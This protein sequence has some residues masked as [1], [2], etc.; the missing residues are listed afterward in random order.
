M[1]DPKLGQMVQLQ[2]LDFGAR[3]LFSRDGRTF[4]ALVIGDREGSARFAL[5]LAEITGAEKATAMAPEVMASEALQEV[6]AVDVSKYVT[7]GAHGLASFED[8]VGPLEPGAIIVQERGRLLRCVAWRRQGP[9]AAY[10]DLNTSRF[11]KIEPGPGY[12]LRNWPIVLMRPDG[13]HASITQMGERK[14]EKD[15]S[16]Y[17]TN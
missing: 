11:A 7:L 9:N 14:F 16:P 4:L 12:V 1:Q 10:V 5:L 17:S 13:T 8:E 2:A 15:Q 6:F 3:C